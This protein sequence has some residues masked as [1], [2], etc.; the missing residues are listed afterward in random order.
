MGEWRSRSNILA[1]TLDGG[2]WSDSHPICLIPGETAPSIHCIGGWVGPIDSLDSMQKRKIFSLLVLEPRSSNR[3]SITIPALRTKHWLFPGLSVETK[4]TYISEPIL[5]LQPS[6]NPAA[7]FRLNNSE[8]LNFSHIWHEFLDRDQSLYT[9]HQN[10]Y[11]MPHAGCC[12][13]SQC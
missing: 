12:S 4:F 6:H 13:Q 10:V 7:L 9:V 5:F 8:I 2:E 11:K 1:S 3:L